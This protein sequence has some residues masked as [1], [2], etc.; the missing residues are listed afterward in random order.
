MYT[1][2]TA[3]TY[4][5]LAEDYISNA[6]SGT[7]ALGPAVTIVSEIPTVSISSPQTVGNAVKVSGTNFDASA[8]VTLYLNNPGSSIVL[9]TATTDSSGDFK[10]SITIPALSGTLDANGSSLS[11]S[12]YDIVAQETNAI[13]ST[14]AEGGITAH[15]PFDIEPTLVVTPTSSSGAS[16]STFTLTGAGFVAGQTLA[17]STSAS[18][19]NSITLDTVVTYHSLVTV[20]SDGSFTVTV[21]LASPGVTSYGAANFKLSAST[22]TATDYFPAAT[23]VSSP[24]PTDLGFSFSAPA[25]DETVTGQHSVGDPIVSAVWNFPASTSVKIYLGPVLLGTVTTDSNG[26]AA[27]PATAV[28][29]AMVAGVYKAQAVTS[30]GLYS[31]QISLTVASFFQ[32]TDPSGN[33]M[34]NSYNEYF[35]SDGNYTV[36]AYGLSSTSSYTWVDSFA[37]ASASMTAMV[38]LQNADGTWTPAVNGTLIFVESPAYSSS[39]ATGTS[40]ASFVL[41]LGATSITGSA[42][43]TYEAIGPITLVSPGVSLS[44]NGAG[45]TG[46]HFEAT[47]ATLIPYGDNVYP[48]LSDQYNVYIGSSELTFGA[49]ASSTYTSSTGN[50][51]YANPSLANG[52]YNISIVYSGQSLSNAIFTEPVVISATSSSLQAGTLVLYAASS[53]ATDYSIVGYGFDSSATVALYYFTY[54]GLTTVSTSI[55]PSHGGFVEASTIAIPP[56]GPAGTYSV[57]A[58]A[59]LGTSTYTATTSYSVE[60]N[61]S[62]NSGTF[63]G[64]AGSAATLTATGLSPS[65]YYAVYFDSMQVATFTTDSTGSSSATVNFHIP[66]VQPG[67]YTVDVEV[68]TSI[69]SANSTA[70]STGTVAVSAGFAVTA[71]TSITLSTDAPVAFPGQLVTFSWTPATQPN[72]ILSGGDYGSVE[73]TVLFNGTAIS[74]APA[75]LAITTTPV[76]YLN[77]SFLMPNDAVGDFWTV[78]F[79]WTQVNYAGSTPKVDTYTSTGS[80]YIQLVSGNGALLTGI[81][82]SQ[83]AT[84]TTAVGNQI[85]TSMKVPLSELNASVASIKGL[86]ANI[87]TAFGTMT[88]TLSTINA[89]VA[90]IESGMVV[91]QTDLGSISTS[92]ASLNASIAAFNGNVATIS[93]TLGNVQTSLSSIGTTVTGNANGIA[94]ITT[95]L[96]TLS[97]TVSSMN[98]NVGTISTNLGTLNANVTK[99]SS[100]ISS[101]EIFLIVIV[102]LVLITLVLSFLAINSVNR[103]SKKI[104]EQKKQ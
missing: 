36:S 102:V 72:A 99:I 50:V 80:A 29:P 74:T 93:T 40:P 20:A 26:Y 56:A 23:Y 81:T 91:V 96:G 37:T 13:S 84:L 7:Y 30:V 58:I 55:T 10:V 95:D 83:I 14:Y 51:T 64:E 46:L 32:V 33:V 19:S 82:S 71:A 63:N 79:Q 35:P 78:S 44:N 53:S 27:L 1:G 66:A 76:A 47:A 22:P 89:T 34:S 24:D 15:N 9:G 85:T 69:P 42:T 88:T 57:F 48:G 3:G 28:I 73:V 52:I 90:S 87:T 97:G 62:I 100:P 77:G 101:L 86:T 6:P 67:D 12:A 59:T 18:P 5:I 43:F 8:S 11:I 104:E 60:A 4:Y 68:L 75:A 70:P 45:T 92:L 17:A 21:T 25:A 2:A 31:S 65:Q 49:A 38:G 103:V 39:H 61:I 54:T 16:G 41:K 94:T 98:G